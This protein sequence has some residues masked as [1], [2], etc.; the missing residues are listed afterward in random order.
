MIANY[1]RLIGSGMSQL[2]WVQSQ[3]MSGMSCEVWAINRYASLFYAQLIYVTKCSVWA[4][5]R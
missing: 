2:S 4:V 1:V 5:Y 3:S